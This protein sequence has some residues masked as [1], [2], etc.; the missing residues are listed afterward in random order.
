MAVVSSGAGGSWLRTA[1]TAVSAT[2]AAFASTF[3]AEDE[4][5]GGQEQERVDLF[6]LER[7]RPAA[8]EATARSRTFASSNGFAAR[9]RAAASPVGTGAVTATR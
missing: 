1:R 2:A 3:V 8:G 5:V 4:P 9:W 7:C 6:V